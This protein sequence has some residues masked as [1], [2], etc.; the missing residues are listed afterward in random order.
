MSSSRR[1]RP[2]RRQT[3]SARQD[4]SGQSQPRAQAPKPAWRQ[5]IDQ[6]GGI[7]VLAAVIIVPVIVVAMIVVGG[8]GADSSGAPRGGEFVVRERPE[9]DGRREGSANAPVQIIEYADFSCPHCRE[10]HEG[11]YDQ[12]RTE[13]I[14]SGLVS[15]EYKYVS[16]LGPGSVRAAQAAECANEQGYFWDMHDL[17]YLRQ[18]SGAFSEDNLKDFGQEIKDAR[19]DFDLGRYESCVESEATESTVEADAQDADENGVNSTP[20]F[21]INGE[22]VGGNRSM[23]ELRGIINRYLG[24]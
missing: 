18:A 16:F 17:L 7:P 15:L 22:R 4:G 10:F 23:D 14:E 1:N 20:T 3:P 24:R 19:S 8:G 11:A 21:F 6:W 13:Y 12:L 2:T 5:T 9:V